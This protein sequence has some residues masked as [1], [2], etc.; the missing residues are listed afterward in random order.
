MW[1]SDNAY[2]ALMSLD[3]RYLSDDYLAVIVP[4]FQYMKNMRDCKGFEKCVN[5]VIP[6]IP[7][8]MLELENCLTVHMCEEFRKDYFVHNYFTPEWYK[9]NS[10]PLYFVS[11]FKSYK[12]EPYVMVKMSPHLPLFDERFVNYG[13]DK[14]S[15]I[16]HL[17]YTGYKFA[18]L[19]N[20]FA[21]DVPHP[22]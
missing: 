22:L 2:N 10:R 19:K 20:A 5:S 15:W 6:Y 11:C 1:P 16:E 7:R 8:T 18:V 9:H 13:K 17:R 21:I 12:Q 3:A 14:I 4:S